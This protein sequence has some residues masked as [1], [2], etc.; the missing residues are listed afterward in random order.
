MGRQ[1]AKQGHPF[2]RGEIHQLQAPLRMALCHREQA[3]QRQGFTDRGIGGPARAQGIH[4]IAHHAALAEAG[5][6]GGQQHWLHAAFRQGEAPLQQRQRRALIPLRQANRSGRQLIAMGGEVL[7]GSAMAEAAPEQQLQRAG[8]CQGLQ[9]LRP[10][11]PA[12]GAR[13]QRHRSIASRKRR[14]LHGVERFGC[15]GGRILQM[16]VGIHQRW[17]QQPA[18]GIQHLG[19][20]GR[21]ALG[22]GGPDRRQPALADQHIACQRL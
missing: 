1:L 15:A 3:L 20:K 13:Q 19:A 8:G 6:A 22:R 4:A 17:R 14:A 2:S 7:A 11:A 5:V 21:G 18:P 16:G 12:Q 10:I 9:A